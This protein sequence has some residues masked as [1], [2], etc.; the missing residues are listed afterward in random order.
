MASFSNLHLNE[1]YI[2]SVLAYAVLLKMWLIAAL[3]Y[4]CIHSP[5]ISHAEYLEMF[6]DNSSPVNKS[7]AQSW[8]EFG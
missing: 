5:L 2:F 8:N 4:P 3:K 7:K 6:F 1:N